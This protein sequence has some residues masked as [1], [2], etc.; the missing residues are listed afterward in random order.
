MKSSQINKILLILL[1]LLILFPFGICG[2]ELSHKAEETKGTQGHL[3]KQRFN[4]EEKE[5]KDIDEFNTL[6]EKQLSEDS[7]V[8]VMEKGILF[9]PYLV[10]S[11][12]EPGYLIYNEQG[13]YIKEGKPGHRVFLK[14]GNYSILIGS[15]PKSL[16]FKKEV[17]IKMEQVTTVKPDWSALIIDTVDQYGNR[18]R[19]G[20]LVYNEETKFLTVTG[21]GA[22][23]S[24]GE[25]T[26][27]WI[28]PPDLYRVTKRGETS[29]SLINY[30]T[31]R[32]IPGKAANV[33]MIF[34]TETGRIIGGG[35]TTDYF[36]F[37]GESGWSFNNLISGVFSFTKAENVQGKQN[38]QTYSFGTEVKSNINFDKNKYYMANR[39]EIFEYFQSTT[40]SGSDADYLLNT[41]DILKNNY[42][43]IYRVNNY[44]GPY[45]SFALKTN[46]FNH[47]AHDLDNVKVIETDG[48]S[49]ILKDEKSFMIS[50]F[51]GYTSLQEGIGLNVEYKYTTILNTFL[52]M[53][54]GLKQ[55]IAR[56]V[57][58]FN[59]DSTVL[60]RVNGYESVSGPEISL[61][62]T[63]SPFSFL[64]INIDML[65]LFPDL[66]VEK[67]YFTFQSTVMLS[68][69]SFVSLNYNLWIERNGSVDDLF[70]ITHAL[71]VQIYY[72]FY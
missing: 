18:K 69:S 51:L 42:V 53:G 23:A 25:R 67:S 9:I 64:D 50:N 26:A 68:L 44:V 24:K 71:T 29:D 31:V 12:R 59:E 55:D 45:V 32:T 35:E 4:K 62:V 30:I 28:L 19:N 37:T 63:S 27:V 5:R 15:G 46:L 41:R 65:T 3:F 60:T 33:K 10:D 61:Y 36:F 39:L 49:Y 58:L 8:P 20:Y 21:F 6:I 34:D 16:R 40:T 22:D 17:T 43:A 1:I 54:W 2:K 13:K 70:Q 14:P 38:T 66:S 7:T 72:R 52:R 56:K 48:S 47:Y 57:Y 11:Q